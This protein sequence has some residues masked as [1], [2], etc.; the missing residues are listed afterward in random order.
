MCAS[1]DLAQFNCRA[2]SRRREASN[3]RRWAY[4]NT[5]MP[6][7]RVICVSGTE[8]GHT[9]RVTQKSFI[10][11][12]LDPGN[13]LILCHGVHYPV[14]EHTG[15]AESAAAF[16]SVLL[17]SLQP[18][19]AVFVGLSCGHA[20]AALKVSSLPATH[21]P[22]QCSSPYCCKRETPTCARPNRC[23]GQP[24]LRARIDNEI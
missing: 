2:C 19:A 15:R 20:L 24:W 16:C 18:L 4:G 23:I 1:R 7:T 6:R 5:T 12:F 11:D 14:H 10:R 3:L 17:V 13:I 8:D 21:I 9:A 22:Q